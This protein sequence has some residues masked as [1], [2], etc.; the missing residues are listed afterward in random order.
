MFGLR[1]LL[2]IPIC[3]F[4]ETRGTPCVCR[5]VPPC[6]NVRGTCS[7]QPQAFQQRARGEQTVCRR[8]RLVH[9]AQL[10]PGA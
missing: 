5:P 8:R 4:I 6:R 9:T 1:E 7:R 2:D 10:Y 3:A